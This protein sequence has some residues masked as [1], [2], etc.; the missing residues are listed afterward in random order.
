MAIRRISRQARLGRIG[1]IN[2]DTGASRMYQSMANAGQNIANSVL[3][4]LREEAQQRGINAAKEVNR[5]N[6]IEFDDE[7]NPKA[8]TVP[9]N[10]G[11][12]A[13]SAYQTVV[14]RRFNES[15]QEEIVNKSNE[16]SKK[17]TTNN[18]IDLQG[19]SDQMASYLKAMDESSGGRFNEFISNTGRSIMTETQG[20]LAIAAAKK[21]REDAIATAKYNTF[22]AIEAYNDSVVLTVTPTTMSILAEKQ[23]A[24][25]SAAEEEFGLTGDRI[26]Y[27]KNIKIAKYGDAAAR[28]NILSNSAKNLSKSEKAILEAAFTNRALLPQIEDVALRNTIRTI[29]FLAPDKLADLQSSF[30]SNIDALE[31]IQSEFENEY[32][33]LPEII[34][35]LESFEATSFQGVFSVANAGRNLI[36]D[37][38]DTAKDEISAIVLNKVS[39]TFRDNLVNSL[40]RLPLD[41]KIFLNN[42]EAALSQDNED[43]ELVNSLPS[44]RIKQDVQGLIRNFSYEERQ[45]ILKEAQ[46]ML[47]PEAA[48]IEL[49]FEA[50]LNA[51]K[52]QEFDL[53]Q[54]ADLQFVELNA[55]IEA[56]L[57]SGNT[58]IASKL[59][60]ELIESDFIENISFPVEKD[61][62]KLQASISGKV[63][64]A[65]ETKARKANAQQ[66]V[67]IL[68]DLRNAEGYPQAA[69][70]RYQIKKAAKRNVHN[71]SDD[72]IN[73]WLSQADSLFSKFE[74]ENEGNVKLSNESDARLIRENLE[75]IADNGDV[76]TIDQ[77]NK[78]KSDVKNLVFEKNEK[79]YYELES[80]LETSYARSVVNLVHENLRQLTN[81]NGIEPNRFAVLLSMS[82]EEI[83]S[84]PKE[85]A[86]YKIAQLLN[87]ARKPFSAKSE[88]RTQINQ[89]KDLN[90]RLFNTF[91]NELD[92]KTSIDNVRRKGNVADL[93]DIK[94][95]ENEVYRK[96]ANLQ[97]GQALDFDQI[98]LTNERGKLTEMGEQIRSDFSKGIIVP[99]IKDY[100]N[101]A[102]IMGAVNNQKVFQIFQLGSGTARYGDELNIWNQQGTVQLY[103][104]T[105]ARLGAAIL[106][107]EAGKARTPADALPQI[108][109]NAQEL[110]GD[111]RKSIEVAINKELNVWIN[112]TYSG[113]DAI[114]RQ[115]L[116]EAALAF[117]FDVTSS[118]DLKNAMDSWIDV[119]FGTDNMVIGNRIDEDKVVGARTKYLNAEEMRN[120]DNAAF[121]M[122]YESLSEEDQVRFF[123]ELTT[124]RTAAQITSF[125]AGMK[126]APTSTIRNQP[127]TA[128]IDGRA[129]LPKLEL[130]L[131]ESPAAPGI[132]FLYVKT[133]MGL[134]QQYG[135]N[136]APLSIDAFDFKSR[137]PAHTFTETYQTLYRSALQNDPNGAQYG[138]TSWMDAFGE[139]LGLVD[140][141]VTYGPS[142]ATIDAERALIFSRFPERINDNRAEFDRLVEVRAILPEHVD[143]FLRFVDD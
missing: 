82:Q 115:K 18:K 47:N 26:A 32:L 118:K 134:Q 49:E 63:N 87:E 100:L 142:Q 97:E 23:Q 53:A 71:H 75:D 116:E 24:V 44:T 126:F 96:L 141:E 76:I 77:L 112:D 125:L 60:I 90:S 29:H 6:L 107:Y 33:S 108:V 89:I 92:R 9:E 52:A 48:I 133:D 138:N 79:L 14:E 34:Q 5:Q 40:T 117:G 67:R 11:K 83:N 119:T 104:K 106:M 43:A 12:I 143:E 140:S 131:K 129:F 64:K 113:A 124:V 74:K 54:N 62:K 19:Y 8:L 1:I 17:F 102:A 114:T 122:L 45:T 109:S 88:V 57:D 56:A 105:I 59:Y 46:T 69:I 91:K 123:K 95:Y 51:Q 38:P 30:K 135:S 81:N 68:D 10:F 78:A 27:E 36:D 4:Q 128:Q 25:T 73:G 86:E 94:V 99:A 132:Y 98:E 137:E 65:N 84:L 101:R 55:Q 58:D 80:N 16:L 15:I 120:M 35:S 42:L 37:A 121:Q 127:M 103:E 93:D 7:G 139:M 2:T 72:K 13:A 70:I 3:P 20:K 39:S 21:A 28:T 110:G 41:N 50:E 111:I 66:F 130:K 61:F 22:K 85:G 136:G 31:N